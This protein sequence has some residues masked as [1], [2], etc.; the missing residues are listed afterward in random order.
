MPKRILDDLHVRA[1]EEN[2]PN[3]ACFD[4]FDVNYADVNRQWSIS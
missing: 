3:S 2:H 4:C 1:Y